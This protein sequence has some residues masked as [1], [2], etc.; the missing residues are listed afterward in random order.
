[1]KIHVQVHICFSSSLAM[2]GDIVIYGQNIQI[3]T[4]DYI[5]TQLIIIIY[6]QI[7]IITTTT[8]QQQSK[9]TK[10]K[11]ESKMKKGGHDRD[12]GTFFFIVFQFSC[13]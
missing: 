9:Q 8:I 10:K 11:I 12:P 13:L 6:T 7:K 2:N 5:Y 3:L 4:I 1:M